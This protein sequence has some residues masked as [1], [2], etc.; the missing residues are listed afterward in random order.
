MVYVNTVK[1][2]LATFLACMG[3]LV[4]PVSSYQGI[5]YMKEVH[6]HSLG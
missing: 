5:M 3:D 4:E 1:M 2:W 6:I